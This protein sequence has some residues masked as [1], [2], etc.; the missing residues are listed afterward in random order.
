MY[1]CDMNLNPEQ[2]YFDQTIKKIFSRQHMRSYL[3][4]I[5]KYTDRCTGCDNSSC[6][7][8]SKEGLVLSEEIVD[9][10]TPISSKFGSH[11]KEFV[12]KNNLNVSYRHAF[13]V[14]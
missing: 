10:D 5:S 2:H 4:V 13:H 11:L 1:V 3:F 8:L 6:H 14:Y 12:S 7:E 9:D